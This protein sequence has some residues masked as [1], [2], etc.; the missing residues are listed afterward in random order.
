MLVVSKNPSIT[1]SFCVERFAF[2]TLFN[3]QY[4]LIVIN[5]TFLFS[6]H[7][8]LKTVLSMCKNCAYIRK[9][10]AVC[11]RGTGPP[12]RDSCCL[13]LSGPSCFRDEFL[14]HV[15]NYCHLAFGEN[16]RLTLA[17]LLCKL[18][19]LTFQFP[20]PNSPSKRPSDTQNS[21]LK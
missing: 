18:P 6:F 7:S 20:L 21:L 9:S 3:F 12:S 4:M 17:L 5:L 19:F 14:Q 8:I 1:L 10:S 16:L 13:K 15:P 2:C 11:E